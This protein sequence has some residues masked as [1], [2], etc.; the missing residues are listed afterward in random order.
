MRRPMDLQCND[1]DSFHDFFA[2]YNF[3]M[4][5]PERPAQELQGILQE[6]E[7]DGYPSQSYRPKGYRQ[8]PKD[9]KE[10]NDP[11]RAR[12]PERIWQ[13]GPHCFHELLYQKQST[14]Q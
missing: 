14:G 4:P 2:A 5:L 8:F 3:L 1:S 10:Y 9:Q 7:V 12:D 13:S 6:V 11:H